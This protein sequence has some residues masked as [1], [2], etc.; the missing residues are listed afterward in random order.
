MLIE[1]SISNSKNF[2]EVSR[3]IIIIGININSDL[4]TFDI[5]YRIVYS[6]EG[7]DVSNL[8]KSEVPDWHINNSQ[9]IICRDENFVPIQNPDFKEQKNENGVIINEYEKYYT[10]PAFDY[11]T[12]LI[13]EKDV[14]LKKIISAYIIEQDNDG[15]FN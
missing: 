13:L 11:I 8:F 12:Q 7:K 3:S 9:Q 15:K 2:Q 4:A 10:M 1:Q 5:Y 14:P 6:K